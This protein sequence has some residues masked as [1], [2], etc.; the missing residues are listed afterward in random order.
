MSVRR[1]C[2]AASALCLAPATLAQTPPPAINLDLV[3]AVPGN[4]SYRIIGG[5]SEADFSDSGG[6]VRLTVRCT[7]ASK[8]VSIIRS[9]AL[10]AAPFLTVTTSYGS[11][12]VSAGFAAGNL[13]GVVAAS[14]PL[15]DQIAFSRGKWAIAN[16][17]EGA[18]V[19]PSW[20]DAARVIEDCRS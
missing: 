3:Q 4:W 20:A 16:S 11:R 2:A 19:V 5:G 6:H 12:N 10:A 14:D 15:L 8:I 13:S 7:Q 18:L 9:G 17:G 1:A